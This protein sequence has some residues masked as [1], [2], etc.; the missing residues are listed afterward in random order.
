M[1]TLVHSARA[2]T[3]RALAAAFIA[4]FTFA[5]IG[6][7]GT[8]AQAEP[9]DIKWGTGPVGSVGHK[10]LVVLADLLNKEMPDYRITVLPMPGAVMTVKGYATDQIDAMY[11][12]DDA[13]REFAADSGRFKGFKATMKRQPVQSMW[14][15][16]LDVGLAQHLAGPPLVRRADAAPVDGVL[17]MKPPEDRDG[18]EGDRAA[19][20]LA[21]EVREQLRLRVSR[22]PDLRVPRSRLRRRLLPLGRVRERLVRTELDHRAPDVLILVADVHERRSGPI[23]LPCQRAHELGVLDEPLEEH[24]LPGLNVR[25]DANGQLRVALDP[26]LAHASCHSSFRISGTSVP[27]A[28]TASTSS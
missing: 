17:A 19:D 20:A 21:V 5:L 2:L 26:V 22:R 28:S 23:R 12:S 14:V 8:A 3:A 10:A 15:F 18:V 25:A 6:L 11:A 1:L 13:L 24:L 27:S 16:T 9:K 4:A 7:S